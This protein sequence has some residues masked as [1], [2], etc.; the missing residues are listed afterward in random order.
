MLCAEKQL[1]TMSAK[2]QRD[3]QVS[4]ADVYSKR[5]LLLLVIPNVLMSLKSQCGKIKT[6][7]WERAQV[8]LLLMDMHAGAQAVRTPLGVGAVFI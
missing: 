7:I 2:E 3:W 4:T 5:H 6:D 1:H 8:P